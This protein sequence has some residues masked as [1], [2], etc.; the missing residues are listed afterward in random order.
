[1]NTAPDSPTNHTKVPGSPGLSF[2]IFPFS[3][4]SDKRGASCCEGV[5]QA[6]GPTRLRRGFG[7]QG[8]SAARARA[9]S[10]LNGTM[11]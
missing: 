10:D 7:G 3:F 1:M 2:F 5:S 6:D 4:T 11:P 9:D 8:V